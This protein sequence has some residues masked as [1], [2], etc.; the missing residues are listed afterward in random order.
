MCDCM[1]LI[2]LFYTVL[3]LTFKVW[4]LPLEPLITQQP[5]V[6]KYPAK[7]ISTGQSAQNYFKLNSIYRVLCCKNIGQL[8][9]LK[10]QTVLEV[11]LINNTVLFREL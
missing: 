11:R 4:D 6:N 5:G 7:T 2:L 10:T 1:Y 8:P 9:A 3:L